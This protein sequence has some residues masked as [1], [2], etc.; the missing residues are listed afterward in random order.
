METGFTLG[1]DGSTLRPRR[2]Q[3]RFGYSILL[4]HKECKGILVVFM[5]TCT[6]KPRF[7]ARE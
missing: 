7:R 1:D 5:Q 2:I 6:E 4:L 3:T